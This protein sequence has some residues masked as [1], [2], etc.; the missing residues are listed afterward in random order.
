MAT[1][2]ST[3]N[4]DLVS[5]FVGDDGIRSPS[6]PSHLSNALTPCRDSISSPTS[7]E[8]SDDSMLTTD[9]LVVLSDLLGLVNPKPTPSSK[10]T[11]RSKSDRSRRRKRPRESFVAP[12]GV[13]VPKSQQARQKMEIEFLKKQVVEMEATIEKM[14]AR[15]L[16]RERRDLESPRAMGP[17]TVVRSNGDDW[18]DDGKEAVQQL[19]EQN[20]K[21]RSQVA[22]HL[23]DLKRLELVARNR[24]FTDI[25]ANNQQCM[26]MQTTPSASPA[27]WCSS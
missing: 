13:T 8:L 16:E 2:I 26:M 1:T 23:E 10:K 20:E 17:G 27:Y 25:N 18:F 14:Q 5:L 3:D 15:K 12:D 7:T 22:S 9:D 11:A 19:E 4:S 24:F 21:L 6:A